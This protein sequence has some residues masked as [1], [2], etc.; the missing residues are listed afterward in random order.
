MCMRKRDSRFAQPHLHC[1][2]AAVSQALDAPTLGMGSAGAKAMAVVLG[3]AEIYLHSGGQHQW[4]NCAPV[5]V[6]LAAGLH[7]S[8]IDGSPLVYNQPGS[9]MPDLLICRRELADTVLDQVAKC[10]F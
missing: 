8:R 3:E 6:A 7:A 2:G 4:D 9:S 5:A 10:D 1:L